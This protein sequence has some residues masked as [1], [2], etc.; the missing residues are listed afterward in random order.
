MYKFN[1]LM[2]SF[3]GKANCNIKFGWTLVIGL[4]RPW[5]AS[6][7]YFMRTSFSTY[8]QFKK[9]CIDLVGVS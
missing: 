6:L 2:T 3:N 8:L 5:I 1:G 7:V 4:F 9:I